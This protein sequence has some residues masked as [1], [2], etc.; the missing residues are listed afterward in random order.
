M[1]YDLKISTKKYVHRNEVIDLPS[2]PPC[3][4]V[5]YLHSSRANSIAYLWK[6]SIRPIGNAQVMLDTGWNHDG[7]IQWV[8][9]VFPSGIESILIDPNYKM[10]ILKA[11]VIP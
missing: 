1:M 4:H 5:L 7:T 11:A 9:E 2:L 6:S 3:G 10:I 8:D